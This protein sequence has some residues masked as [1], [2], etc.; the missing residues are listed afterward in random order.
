MR[1]ILAVMAALFASAPAAASAVVGRPVDG[2]IGFQ[3]PATPVMQEIVAFH[4]LLLLIIMAVA[5]FVTALLVYVIFRYNSAAN[6]TPSK[7]SHNT[8]IEVIWTGVPVLI[9]VVIAIPSFRLLYFQDVVP[10]ADMTVKAVGYQW[11]WRYEIPDDGVDEYVSNMLGEDEV[12]DHGL[13]RLAVDSP[14]VVP[15]GATV[16]VLVTSDPG[17]TGVIHSWA[18]PSFGVREDAIP[19]RLN[20]TWFRVDEP[21]AY[22]GQCA[23]LCGRNHAFMPIE[24]RVVPRDVYARW[25][26]A[27]RED[28]GDGDV[29]RQVLAEYETE[30]AGRT[31]LAAAGQE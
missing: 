10:E 23:E 11:H 26:D 6:R 12:E 1:A 30:R 7:F 27:A 5:L 3:P 8:M 15:A 16:R 21:G 25:A 24:V 19:G 29:A 22:Y 9:L 14:L 28:G 4:N 17:P 31:R 2:Q 20:E 18:V 13:Y